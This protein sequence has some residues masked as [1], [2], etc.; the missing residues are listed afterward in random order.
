MTATALRK[1][2][3]PRGL[4]KRSSYGNFRLDFRR[5]GIGGRGAADRIHETVRVAGA[6]L[7]VIGVVLAAFMLLAPDSLGGEPVQAVPR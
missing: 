7:V 3:N 5:S 6:G 4:K 2:R 1:L